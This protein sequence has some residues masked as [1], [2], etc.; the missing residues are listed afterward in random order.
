MAS[1]VAQDWR[2][3]RIA[4]LQAELRARDERLAEQ[5]KRIAELEQQVADLLEKLGPGSQN[6]HLPPSTD[7]PVTRKWRRTSKKDKAQSKR[8]RGA[9]PAHRGA[10]RDLLPPDKVNKFVDL[11]PSHCEDCWQPLPELPDPEAKRSQLTEILPIRRHTTEFRRHAVECANCGHQTCAAYDAATIPAS[12]FGPRL[13]AIMALVV[14]IY[15]LSR[16]KAAALLSDLLGVWVSLGA[17]SAVEARVSE[18]VRPAVEQAWDQVSRAQVKHT[19][20]TSWAQGGVAL[21]LWTIASKAATVFK[22]VASSAKKTLRPL[23]QAARDLG[24]RPRQGAQLLGDGAPAD[25]LES[26][27][28]QIRLV[29]RARWSDR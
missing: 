15:H 29:F 27:H 1:L 13:M 20:G 19:D 12:P 22:I 5:A 10:K 16:R 18:A 14:G 28:P 2:D 9:Q 17:L 8:K 6:S 21:S 7:P 23:L 24:E 11:Y 26:P 3:E 25:L 4:E